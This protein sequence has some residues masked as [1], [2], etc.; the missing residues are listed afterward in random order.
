MIILLKGRGSIEE[1]GASLPSHKSFPLW[2]VKGES[3]RGF[4][5]LIIPLPLSFKGEE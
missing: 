4:A 1:R 3:K 5:S 2:G